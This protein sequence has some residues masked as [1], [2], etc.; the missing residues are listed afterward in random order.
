MTLSIHALNFESMII[1]VYDEVVLVAPID[2]AVSD[3]RYSCAA[4]QAIVLPDALTSTLGDVVGVIMTTATPGLVYDRSS[5]YINDPGVERQFI[6]PGNA[7]TYFRL[8]LYA[9]RRRWFLVSNYSS[10][11]GEDAASVAAEEVFEVADIAARDALTLGDVPGQ[12]SDSDVVVVA[13]ADGEGNEGVYKYYSSTG[14]VKLE[15]GPAAT[16]VAVEKHAAADIAARDALTPG[17]GIGLVGVG[18]LVDVVD[19]DGSGNRVIYQWTGADYVPVYAAVSPVE[20]LGEALKD[21]SGFIDSD[22]IVC[23]YDDTT[24]KVT[25]THSSGKIKY[26]WRNVAKELTSPWVSAAHVDAA[27]NYFL[28]STDGDT[29]AWTTSPWAWTDVQVTLAMY[30]ID[31]GHSFALREVHG[32]M[33]PIMHQAQHVLT[34][35]WRDKATGLFT[36]GTYAIKDD[37]DAAITPGMDEITMYDEDVKSVEPALTQGSYTL[38]YLNGSGESK[39]LTNQPFPFRVGSTRIKTVEEDLTDTE[40]SNG[41]RVNVYVFGVPV[42]ADAGSQAFRYIWHTSPIIHSNT[43]NAEEEL[44]T[45]LNLG[46]LFDVTPEFVLIGRMTLRIRSSYGTTGKVRIESIVYYEGGRNAILFSQNPA[47]LPSNNVAYQMADLT[48]D[49]TGFVD[50][51]NIDVSYDKSTR[52]VTLTHASGLITYLWKSRIINLTSPWVSDAHT[53]SPG[54]YFLKSTDGATFTWATPPGAGEP[55]DAVH[56]AYATYDVP[57]GNG[58]AAREIHGVM[59]HTVHH[60][61]HHAIGCLKEKGTGALTAATYEL[62]PA[63]PT[64][65]HNTPGIDATVLYD[66]DLKSSLD[67]LIQGSY[68]VYWRTGA[69]VPNLAYANAVPFVLDGS[70]I[71]YNNWTGSEY[72]LKKVKKGKWV[73]YYCVAMPMTSDADSQKHRFIWVPGSSEFNALELAQAESTQLIPVSALYDYDTEMV[74]VCRLTFRRQDAYS[75]IGRCRIEDVTIYEGT[76]MELIGGTPAMVTPHVHAAGDLMGYPVNND[77]ASQV[78][79]GYAVEVDSS[80]NFHLANTGTDMFVG[81]NANSDANQDEQM[82]L[83]AVCICEAQC[84]LGMIPGDKLMIYT[85]NGRLTK[86]PDLDAQRC[87]GRFIKYLGGNTALVL[88]NPLPDEAVL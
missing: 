26:L 73:N 82:H 61:L 74:P 31:T 25:L 29:F 86:R 72:E 15:Y 8:H 47:S 3:T 19:G 85:T 7:A 45:V 50:E 35:T 51:D 58:F 14:Y 88:L 71:A 34:G 55:F 27:A 21:A 77:G 38:H 52:K 63:T 13:D 79:T 57:S 75:S 49:L 1:P 10:L 4:E 5:Q 20:A 9:G 54:K 53:D 11:A 60:A 42:T 33:Q 17:V 18:D 43:N 65:A 23:T 64:D 67:A 48:G 44:P 40:L 59:P 80:G 62:S 12:V 68:T 36:T 24:R 87:L 32:T 39:L 6:T 22:N 30:E 76:Q 70:D 69:N 41:D 37:T 83:K 66:E 78:P 84:E 16:A 28:H 56:V 46:T 81:I 2:P